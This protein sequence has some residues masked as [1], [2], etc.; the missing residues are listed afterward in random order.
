MDVHAL[1]VDFY[2]FPAH[3]YVL[4][5]DGVAGLY[6]RSDLIERVQPL[7]VA[8][9]ASDDYDLEGHF[10]PSVGS[11]KKFEMPTHS[12]PLLAGVVEAVALLRG[13]GLP[14]IEG[15]LVQLA[16]RLVRGLKRTPGVAL[17]S[18][19]DHALRSALVAFKVREQDPYE[20]CPALWQLG[21]VVGRVVDNERVRLSLALFNDERDVDTALAAVERLTIEGLPSG[22][23]RASDYRALLTEG[24]D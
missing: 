14:A 12:G 4:G 3:K 5:P 21:R 18:P 1:E 7:A 16:G 20:T 17:A 13:T 10:T 22:A 15:R 6:I 2:A 11:M 9:G 24:E 8:L 19:Q 23:L